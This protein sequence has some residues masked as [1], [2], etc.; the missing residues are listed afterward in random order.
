MQNPKCVLVCHIHTTRSTKGHTHRCTGY[1]HGGI[2][3]MLRKC[4]PVISVQVSQ[5]D[6][7]VQPQWRVSLLLSAWNTTSVLSTETKSSPRLSRLFPPFHRPLNSMF[8]RLFLT[9][10][11]VSLFW[12]EVMHNVYDTGAVH[13]LYYICIYDL[14]KS[15]HEKIAANHNLISNEDSLTLC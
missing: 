8:L 12:H 5:W 7:A 13:V 9:Q 14:L 11:S 4:F 10:T 6:D 15:P 3:D 2:L 1:M